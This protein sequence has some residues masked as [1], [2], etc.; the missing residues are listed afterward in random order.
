MKIFN[1]IVTKTAG[2]HWK[3]ANL[4]Y[5]K[6]TVVYSLKFVPMEIISCTSCP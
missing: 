2:T 4:K 3:K 5:I 1:V 6:S